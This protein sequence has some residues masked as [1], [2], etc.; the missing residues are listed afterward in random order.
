MMK[1]RLLHVPDH[2]FR[3]YM[4]FAEAMPQIVDPGYMLQKL[5]I[6]DF[7]SPIVSAHEHHE[8]LEIGCGTGVHSSLLSE[9]GSVTATELAAPGSFAGADRDVD[10]ERATVFDSLGNGKVR[11]AY[12]DGK[13]LPFGDRSFDVVFHNSV[14]EHVDDAV[15]F[16]REVARVLRPGG[17]SIGI[18]G[19]PLFCVFRLSRDYVL[20]LPLHL[21]RSVLREVKPSKRFPNASDAF[22]EWRAEG[23]EL[24]AANVDLDMRGFYSRLT[25]FANSPDYNRVLVENI[26]AE[27]GM[28]VDDFLAR[29]ASHFDESVLNR[30]LFYMT[31]Q[32]H[33]Q[34][35]RSVFD[36][37]NEWKIET[38]IDKAEA[39]DLRT[40]EVV[41]FRYH[42]LFEP[43]IDI[44]TNSRLYHRFSRLIHKLNELRFGKPALASEFILVSR[45]PEG[46]GASA[47]AKVINS[48]YE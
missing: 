34:H 28:S 33:G 26:A 44:R 30:F 14:I 48:G 21:A 39:A 22:R 12:N 15:R 47:D 19:T 20:R 18:T 6:Y 9:H 17:V 1:N 31:P 24:S 2:V 37:M 43:T 5:T 13:S 8:I 23:G 3:K 36:E 7:I 10:I 35:Y 25:H 38:W 4:A 40:E 11:F 16:N 29:V 32:T 41:P 42:H 46:H 27:H 45:K